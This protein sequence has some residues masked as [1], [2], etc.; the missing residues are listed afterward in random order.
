MTNGELIDRWSNHLDPNN[1]KMDFGP[2]YSFLLGLKEDWDITDLMDQLNI[3]QYELETSD[4]ETVKQSLKEIDILLHQSCEVVKDFFLKIM[5]MES[6]N[7][8]TLLLHFQ[9]SNQKL[10][11]IYE[12]ILKQFEM[13]KV[14]LFEEYELVPQF[15]DHQND[16]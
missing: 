1:I 12:T 7:G 8:E 10:W 4:R 5:K 9:S 14:E 16:G 6:P 15:D 11:K 3:D 13:I 2:C